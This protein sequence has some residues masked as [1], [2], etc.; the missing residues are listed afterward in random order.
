MS[1]WVILLKGVN[2]GGHKKVKSADLVQ[3][4]TAAGL[5][6][7]STYIQSGNILAS[8]TKSAKA[9]ATA[10]EAQLEDDLGL[11][12]RAIVR[13]RSELK[14]AC[15]RAQSFGD[16]RD[17]KFVHVAFLSARPKRA[18]DAPG[19]E[20]LELYKDHALIFYTSGSARSKLT[21]AWL[22]KHLQIDVATARNLNTTRKILERL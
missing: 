12:T 11:T 6:D 7:V 20:V 16:G 21:A 14:A 5:D 18:V 2:V 15:D 3:T 1:R 22:E 8:S 4:A 13:K 9:I 19:D 10:I 17:P